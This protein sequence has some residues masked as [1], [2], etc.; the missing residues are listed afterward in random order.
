MLF[1]LESYHS[2]A[3]NLN[4]LV[5]DL[6][7]RVARSHN[8]ILA[9]HAAAESTLELGAKCERVEVGRLIFGEDD[10]LFGERLVLH[11]LQTV[12]DVVDLSMG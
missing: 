11:A 6:V 2:V 9:G 10:T 5:L 4:L 12:L 1:W 3:L 7:R 8:G